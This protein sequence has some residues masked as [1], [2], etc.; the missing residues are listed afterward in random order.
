MGGSAKVYVPSM[1]GYGGRPQPGSGIKPYENLVFDIT[2]VDVKDKAP[3][4]PMPVM[5]KQ[6]IK[7]DAPQPK[8]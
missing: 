6:N 8:K 7:V 1:L 4:Q 5:P 3:E 2:I